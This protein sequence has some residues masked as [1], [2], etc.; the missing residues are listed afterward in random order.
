[1]PTTGGVMLKRREISGQFYTQDVGLVWL[2]TEKLS[3][4]GTKL[5]LQRCI[6]ITLNG[7]MGCTQPVLV[8][9]APLS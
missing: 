3:K 1:M 5:R 2:H 9:R 6:Q 4:E 7:F 8:H